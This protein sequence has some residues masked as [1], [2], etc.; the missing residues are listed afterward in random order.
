MHISTHL[1]ATLKSKT[2]NT[3][4]HLSSSSSG[5]LSF[6]TPSLCM[7]QSFSQAMTQRLCRTL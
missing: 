1:S 7:A 3:L 6:A 4:S 2:S 5:T